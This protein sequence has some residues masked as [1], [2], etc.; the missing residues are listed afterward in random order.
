MFRRIILAAIVLGVVAAL[1][2]P[3]LAITPEE[4]DLW[5]FPEG[6]N[7]VRIAPTAEGE[8]LRCARGR[9]DSRPA[10]QART[11]SSTSRA[12]RRRVV[13]GADSGRPTQPMVFERMECS[14]PKAHQGSGASMTLRRHA[15]SVLNNPDF[16]REIATGSK[17]SL[18]LESISS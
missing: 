4:L 6:T 10:L 1:A 9:S 15:R 16:I 14:A 13:L 8:P 7:V 2:L 17:S 12:P 18:S 5:G 11:G 3:A